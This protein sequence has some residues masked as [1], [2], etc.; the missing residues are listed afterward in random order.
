MVLMVITIA[1]SKANGKTHLMMVFSAFR[2]L[3]REVASRGPGGC[4]AANRRCALNSL[5]LLYSVK[6][7]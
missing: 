4:M 5:T 1:L 2:R 6:T 7:A 3:Q